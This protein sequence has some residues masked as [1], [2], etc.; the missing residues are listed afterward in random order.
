[1][2]YQVTTVTGTERG[3]GTD[4]DVYITLHGSKGDSDELNLYTG[5]G[6]FDRG[7]TDTFDVSSYNVGT[8]KTISVRLVS[9][10]GHA[11]YRWLC[12]CIQ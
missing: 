8:I 10:T 11:C 7:A 3:A 6:N 5:N 2:N 12:A 1:M 4:A 9:G